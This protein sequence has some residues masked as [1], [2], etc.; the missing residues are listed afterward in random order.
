MPKSK[1]QAQVGVMWMLLLLLTT[2]QELNSA[3]T[4]HVLH[5]QLTNSKWCINNTAMAAF[6]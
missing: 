4:F 6:S 3:K 2:K 5:K 1:P